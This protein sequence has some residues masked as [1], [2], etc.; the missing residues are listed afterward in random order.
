VGTAPPATPP[1]DMASAQPAIVVPAAPTPVSRP[2]HRV[3]AAEPPAPRG[4]LEPPPWL[5]EPLSA[6]YGHLRQ[7]AD[8]I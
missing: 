1:A 6:F 5:D 7:L 3:V 4:D 8:L 2:A